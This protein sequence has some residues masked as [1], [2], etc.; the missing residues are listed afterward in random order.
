MRSLVLITSIISYILKQLTSNITSY[1]PFC[2]LKTPQ[3]KSSISIKYIF[4]HNFM[5]T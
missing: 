5:R 4:E 1:H 2:F 3:S